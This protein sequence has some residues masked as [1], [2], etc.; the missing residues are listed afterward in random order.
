MNTL[1]LPSRRGLHIPASAFGLDTKAGARN[2]LADKALRNMLGLVP[3][4]R[5]GSAPLQGYHTEGDVIR[6]TA[7]GFDLNTLWTEYQALL[8]LL[9]QRRQPIVDLLTYTVPR[10]IERVPQLGNTA[11]FERASE[12]GL[13]KAI[14]TGVVRLVR[15][16]RPVHLAIP[17]RGGGRPG[18][19]RERDHRGG[20]QPP[21]VQ[22]GHVDAVQQCQPER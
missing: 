4:V 15:H 8:T 1:T 5:G 7:D 21:H 6:T 22:H 14:R 20:R 19:Q 11:A 10:N 18:K 2:I 13:P 17:R 3:G 16:R 12:F 9:N